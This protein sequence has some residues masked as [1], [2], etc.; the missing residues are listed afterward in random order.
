M[1]FFN[2]LNLILHSIRFRLALWFVFILA[3]LLFSFSG[4]L[5]YMQIQE[6]RAETLIRLD[7]KLET[8]EKLIVM[9][10]TNP[11]AAGAQG[12]PIIANDDGTLFQSSDVLA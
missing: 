12:F 4:M 8:I 6:L 11:Q 3:I 1:K 2:R 9:D 10:T 5:F 7:S